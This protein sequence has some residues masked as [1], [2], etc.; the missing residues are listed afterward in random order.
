[1]ATIVKNTTKAN[2]VAFGVATKISSLI[3]ESCDH[4]KTT[5]KTTLPDEDGAIVAVGFFGQTESC[6]AS[7]ACNGTFAGTLGG[8]LAFAAGALTGDF[9]L[10]ELS[11]KQAQG[12]FKKF[13]LSATRYPDTETD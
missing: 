1:M 10:E 8:V 7:G 4:G 11:E 3:L 9:Y 5:G 2:S 13:S 12:E 6:A